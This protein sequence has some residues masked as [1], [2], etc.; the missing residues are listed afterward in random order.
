MIDNYLNA[1]WMTGAVVLLA[2]IL[3][4]YYTKETFGKD[5]DYIER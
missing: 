4:V 3:S 5:L 1:A 2:G